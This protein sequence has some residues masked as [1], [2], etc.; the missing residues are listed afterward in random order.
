V[1][2][3]IVFTPHTSPGNRPRN[4]S[5]P[6][7]LRRQ[8]KE[9][10]QG[11][12]WPQAALPYLDADDSGPYVAADDLADL[13]SPLVSHARDES[14]TAGVGGAASGLRETPSGGGV[15]NRTRVLRRFVRASPSAAHYVSTRPLE[16]REQVPV[17]GPVAD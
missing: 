1:S 8:V 17:T 12:P 16:S 6:R 10:V 3:R 7:P 13:V 15:G 2:L 9:P 4:S 14:G 5:L 11:S